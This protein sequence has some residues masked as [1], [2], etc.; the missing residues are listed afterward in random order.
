MI[1]QPDSLPTMISIDKSALSPVYQQIA[2]GLIAL[3]RNGQLPPGSTLPP[4][5]QM[6]TLLQVHRKTVVAAYNE[7]ASQDWTETIA[8]KGITVARRLP[9][10]APQGLLQPPKGNAYEN[11]ADN[12]FLKL[13]APAFSVEKK[14]N[15]RIIINDGFP[16]AR[17]APV[18]IL[19]NQYR[20]FL[21]KS[22]IQ[23][24]FMTGTA[25]GSY[26]LRN[27]I[28]AFLT[29]TRGININAHNVLVTRGAQMAIF[30]A[31]RMLIKPGSVV[32]VGEPTYTMANN[33]FEHFG[34]TLVRVNVDE[35]G[36][37][38]AAIEALCREKKPDLLYVIPHNHHPTTVTLS[39]E[40]RVKLLQLIREYELPVI[41]DDYDYD[42]HYNKSPILPLASADHKGY[43]LYIGSITKS[44][45]SAIR[46][47]YLV[48]S[49]AFVEQAARIREMIE[50]RGDVIMEEALA[51]LYKNGTMARH[52]N[53]AVKLYQKRR[54]LFCDLLEHN[55][56]GMV[57]FTKPTGGMSVWVK[58]EPEYRLPDIAR[59][60]GERG[61]FM[62]DG[63]LYNSGEVDHN[64]LRMGFASMNE[65]EMEEAI[66]ILK[67]LM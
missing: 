37:D 20:L 26:N 28:A 46:V 16:D 58:F 18:E 35:H 61:L 24:Q 13:K 15:Y 32:V 2:N 31:A 39:A 36:I 40:R 33:I 62:N 9:E 10:Q 51:V 25:T 4:S 52:L 21:K 17:I 60:A 48:G 54:D 57:H 12:F 1:V 66:G 38:V 23:G 14:N 56:R 5:R 55:L 27:E 67:Q 59:R 41:E 7:L 49:S 34:A 53:K 29:R 64:A 43:V 63:K 30:M 44:F 6:A 47:G 11:S 3:I 22:Y 50:I 45:A 42:L 8:R 19:L 65:A